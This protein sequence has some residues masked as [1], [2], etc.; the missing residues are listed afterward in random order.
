MTIIKGAS[1]K[2]DNSELIKARSLNLEIYEYNEMVGILSRQFKTICVAG[3]HGKTTTTNMLSLALNTRGVSYLI[4]DGTGYANKESKYFALESCEYKRHF[5]EYSPN[6]VLLDVMIPGIDVIDV[7][8]WI[9]KQGE[10]PI[11]MLTA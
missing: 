3:C 1:I 6:L 11:I 7:L 10:V 9:R 4:G 8:K 2:E 5:L